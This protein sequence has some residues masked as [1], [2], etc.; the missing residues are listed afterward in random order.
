MMILVVKMMVLVEMVEIVV[1]N[2][3]CPFLLHRVN[4]SDIFISLTVWVLPD[5]VVRVRR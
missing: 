4:M 3:A 2:L 1:K 5:A